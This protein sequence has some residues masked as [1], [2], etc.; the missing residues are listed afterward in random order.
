MKLLDIRSQ[1]LNEGPGDK[2]LRT[3]IIEIV[4][5]IKEWPGGWNVDVLTDTGFVM[6]SE[7][8]GISFKSNNLLLYYGDKFDMTIKFAS[9]K[10]IEYPKEEKKMII[11]NNKMTISIYK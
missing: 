9:I 1:I 5:S 6:S 2:T 3:Q 4:E 8:N 7:F 10:S 11:L